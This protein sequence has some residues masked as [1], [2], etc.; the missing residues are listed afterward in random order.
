MQAVQ[1]NPPEFSRSGCPRLQ[2]IMTTILSTGLKFKLIYNL[3]NAFFF[4][5]PSN[6]ATQESNFQSIRQIQ[7]NN[8]VTNKFLLILQ[9]NTNGHKNHINDFQFVLIQTY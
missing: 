9:F 4:N 3:I 1:A 7:I 6:F 8:S 5:K 2:H